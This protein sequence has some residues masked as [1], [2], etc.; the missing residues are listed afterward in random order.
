MNRARAQRRTRA[1]AL[2]PSVGLPPVL[3]GRLGRLR[4]RLLHG[5]QGL[6]RHEGSPG[7]RARGLAAGVFT[8][9]LPFFGLQIVLGVALAAAIRG[10]RMLAAAGTW[11]SNPLTTL[12]ICWMNYQLGVLLIGPGPAWPGQEQFDPERIGSLGWA[13]SCRLMLGS[14]VVGLVAAAVVGLGCWRW[15]HLRERATAA[16]DHHQPRNRV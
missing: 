16:T 9:C 1:A 12:P 7:H 2:I 5:L 10:N 15:L 14:V 6:W 11:I 3:V 13:F 8:G 4:S